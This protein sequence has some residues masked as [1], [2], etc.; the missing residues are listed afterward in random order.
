MGG[1]NG[2]GECAPD[3]ELRDVNQ[4]QFTKMMGFAAPESSVPCGNLCRDDRT[5]GHVALLADS[6]GMTLYYFDRD[7]TGNKSNCNDKCTEKWIPLQAVKDAQPFGGFTVIV[8]NHGIKMWA[9]PYRPLY[10]ADDDKAPGDANGS[11]PQNLWHI[12]RPAN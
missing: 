12:A 11:D 5:K 1:A 9:Y 2:S 10:T 3:D 4:L 7:D 8:R 6:S